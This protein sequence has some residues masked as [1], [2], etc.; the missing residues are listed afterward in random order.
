[1]RTIGRY[2]IVKELGRGAMGVVYL[3]RDPH[4]GRE[5]ALK[6]CALP[7][8]VSEEMAR[9][10][11]ARFLREARAAASLSHPGIVTVYDAGEDPATHVPYIAMEYIAGQTLKERLDR[12]DRPGVAW[13]TAFG[14]VLAEALDVAHKAGIVHRDIKPANILIRDA[15]GAV[16]LA[17]FG[18]ARLKSSDLTQTGAALGSPSYMSPEQVRGLDLDGRSDLF[19]LA[20]V[21]YESLCGRRPFKGDDVVSLAFSIAND[22]QV[23][24]S[25]QSQGLPPALDAFFDRA[26]AKDPAQRF[27]D[28]LAF[29][30]AFVK[31]AAG[32]VP[33]AARADA[34]SRTA[35]DASTV[36]IA[37]AT[38]R[39]PGV[40]G[41][42][43]APPNPPA[44]RG[45]TGRTIG[46][47]IAVIA[48]L[49]TGIALA[50]RA[51]LGAPEPARAIAALDQSPPPP[52][53]TTL[54]ATPAPSPVAVVEAP[55][56]KI[57]PPPAV[58]TQRKPQYSSREV[59]PVVTPAAPKPP[60]VKITIPP[61]TELH[62]ALD[63]ALGSATS[64]AGDVFT[65][66]F[67]QPVLVGDKVAFPAGT[68]VLGHV[69]AVEPATRGLGDKAG[70]ITLEFD[71]VATAS[72]TRAAIA[73]SHTAVGTTSAGK[74]TA[75]IGGSAAG[76][77]LLGRVLG[78]RSKSAIA[79]ALVGAAAGT[80]AA[81]R[82][83]GE[84]ITLPAGTALTVMLSQPVVINLAP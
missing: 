78:H 79:G 81:A 68:N 18:V 46:L 58:A 7:E 11:H 43:P 82:M 45:G 9:Q 54:A 35:I 74:T 62:L 10:F 2:E 19:T 24:L 50:A 12:R 61:G 17:D 1:M 71:K 55:P 72:G 84:E 15:D 5:V 20:V 64:H 6:T 29:R 16:K 67:T 44:R 47:A 23:P 56:E 70:S 48:L 26:L 49:V 21:L 53:A 25:R 31:S 57:T 22:T 76:G 51:R 39:M 73:A 80:A 37:A 38:Q 8:G 3:A 33:G 60:P 69:G 77:A 41:A 32:A 4:L 28:A 42:R 36:G 34:A 30:D 14:A 27:P 65:A 40:V 13:V 52:P 59:T 66:R 63:G 83:H 75:V